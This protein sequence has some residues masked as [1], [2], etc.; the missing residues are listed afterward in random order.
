[1]NPSDNDC[2]V[3]IAGPVGVVIFVREKQNKSSWGDP[4]K[5][6][7]ELGKVQG[8]RRASSLVIPSD[9]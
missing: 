3:T 1:M 9:P 5:V 2:W 8:S 6:Y 7:A 4:E